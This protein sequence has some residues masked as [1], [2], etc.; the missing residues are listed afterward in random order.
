M[1]QKVF[2][3]IVL[4]LTLSLGFCSS[5]TYVLDDKTGLGRV[6]DGI[7]GLSGGGATSRLLVS[8]AEP[9]RS[10]ILDYLFKPNFGA[11]LHILKV[12]IGR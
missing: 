7:G 1:E 4:F 2:A 11:S 10:Q 9:Y 8:Y 12:E 6:F 3:V 5:H